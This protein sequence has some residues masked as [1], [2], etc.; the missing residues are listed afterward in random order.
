MYT[1]HIFLCARH[2]AADEARVAKF[3]FS[4]PFRNFRQIKIGIKF[5][6]SE[7]T[8]NN[9]F[10]DE[11]S[12]VPFCRGHC[13]PVLCTYCNVNHGQCHLATPVAATAL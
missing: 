12:K 7:N 6:T 5:G 10:I 13:L 11:V 8:C 4:K 3:V 2:K 1:M 9:T